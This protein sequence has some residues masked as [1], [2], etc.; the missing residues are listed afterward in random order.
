MLTKLIIL[1][2]FWTKIADI[3]TRYFHLLKIV[4]L[5]SCSHKK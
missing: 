2:Q 3:F 1:K 5:I 4:Q